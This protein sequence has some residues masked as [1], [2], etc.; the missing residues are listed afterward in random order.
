MILGCLSTSILS[1]FFSH[2]TC[3]CV[4]NNKCEVSL[5]PGNELQ[6]QM[7]SVL[8]GTVNKS[9]AC[10]PKWYCDYYFFLILFCRGGVGVKGCA[11]LV[12]FMTEGNGP[13]WCFSC[14]ATCNVCMQ[15][16]R[17]VHLNWGYQMTE[18]A[19]THGNA[20]HFWLEI[21]ARDNIVWGLILWFKKPQ[22]LSWE[23]RHVL[24]SC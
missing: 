23:Y 17:E 14:N 15:P 9:A 21:L 6:P 18:K 7:F 22:N 13:S 20:K 3:F 10:P 16:L 12:F 11:L 1:I 5:E 2:I 24:H 4:P 19:Q 8:P